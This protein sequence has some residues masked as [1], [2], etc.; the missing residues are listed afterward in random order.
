VEEQALRAAIPAVLSAPGLPPLNPPQ[1]LAC[2]AVLQAPL[3]LIQG[4]PGTGKTVTSATL[5]Y[6]MAKSGGAGAQVC[7]R[8]VLAV[9]VALRLLSEQRRVGAV[10]CRASDFSFFLFPFLSFLFLR[11]KE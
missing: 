8:A 3:S 9:G 7:L 2:Q 4:P 1:M 10:L 5:V 6:H 11:R